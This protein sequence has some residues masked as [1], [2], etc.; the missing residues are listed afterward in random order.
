LLERL[1]STDVM[2]G[3]MNR[4]AF[5]QML[6]HRPGRLG[7]SLLVLDMDKMKLVNDSLG[8]E[9]G[10]QFLSHVASVLTAT[11]RAGD[12]VARLGGD[13]FAVMLLNE[14]DQAAA[15]TAARILAAFT[16]TLFEGRPC[17]VSIGIAS[18]DA[19][20]DGDAVLRA[21]DAAMYA[22]KQEG[23]QRY[24]VATGVGATRSALRPIG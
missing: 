24:V 5:D 7:F 9:A 21:A 3:L 4:R 6:A 19:T 11:V 14:G 10:D 17:R 15:E 23:G 18:G 22:A 16:R 12:V 2:T 13:E 8:H 20:S 1:A